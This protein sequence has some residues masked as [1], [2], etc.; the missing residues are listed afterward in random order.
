ME[1]RN[2]GSKQYQ[3]V[4]EDWREDENRPPNS[5]SFVTYRITHEN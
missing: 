5:I 2:E 4:L 3:V 1:Q